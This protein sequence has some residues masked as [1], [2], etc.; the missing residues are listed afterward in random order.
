[1]KKLYKSILF[2]AA[3]LT[4]SLLHAQPTFTQSSMPAIGTT[5]VSINADSVGVS[6]GSA[7][8][9]QTW[10]FAS[11]VPDGTTN[12]NMFVSPS[13]TP[14]ASTFPTS[15]YS[16]V[17]ATTSGGTGYTYMILNSSGLSLIGIA[18]QSSV[19]IVYDY[20]DPQN[21]L[22]FPWTYNSSVSDSYTAFATYV[23]S[24]FTMNQYR[25]GNSTVTADAWGTLTTPEGTFTNT[26]RNT[27]VQHTVDSTTYVG[28]PIPATVTIQ[29]QTSYS[30][31]S[32]S[33]H[34]NLFTLTYTD[35]DQAGS[36]TSSKSVYYSAV[37]SGVNELKSAKPLA[38]YP[39][40]VTNNNRVHLQADD[41]NT[42]N[43]D[44][45]VTDVQGREVKRLNFY[46]TPANH[47][48][49]DIEVSDLTPGLYF[50]RIQQENAQFSSRFVKE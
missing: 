3:L 34:N 8:A 39:N 43:A 23:V 5:V 35:I 41:M 7:G 20:S 2:T 32:S 27:T 26:L 19:N 1:M 10:N 4:G 31:S 28:F 33:T 36:L 25:Y 13:T 49:V 16:G 11:V 45:I 42:G 6:Q 24:G 9:N 18:I 40:P 50:I 48:S 17:A 29:D 21:I 12:T 38:A 47:H 46:V 22:T 30:W 14:Y 37:G 15:N 44:F